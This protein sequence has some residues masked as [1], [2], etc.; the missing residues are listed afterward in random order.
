VKDQ[1][2]V[3]HDAASN[4]DAP[5]GTFGDARDPASERQA[6]STNLVGLPPGLLGST[7]FNDHPCSLHIH[8]T[9]ESNP[10]LFTRI[11]ACP[12]LPEAGVIFQDYMD[13]VFGHETQR[14]RASGHPGRRRYRS[15]Y[16]GLLQDWGFD[17]NNPQGAVLKGWVESRFGLFPTFHKAPLTRFGGHE[18]MRYVEEKMNSRYHNN[19][20][21]LQLDL[22]FEFCQLAL[23]RFTHPSSAHLVLYRGI[24][25]LDA[26]HPDKSEGPGEY[27]VR[28]NNV[29]SFTRH[30]SIATEFGAHV[31]EARVPIVK[32]VFFSELLPA[33]ALRG[34]AEVIAI[35]GNYRVRLLR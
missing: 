24:D 31:L 7:S 15:S 13:V 20:I 23:R 12:S 25:T 14:C 33:H 11:E 4:G 32:L 17:S 3:L 8:G 5:E 27:V 1:C 35:G 34:E 6:H 16:L 19:C 2:T 10:G 30:P 22:L 9:R 18:W 29:V 26:F 28:L 21:L